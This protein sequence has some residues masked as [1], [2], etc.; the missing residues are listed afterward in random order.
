[1]NCASPRLSSSMAAFVSFLTQLDATAAGVSATTNTP[2]PSSPRP[3]AST[4]F[5]PG[6]MLSG[7]DPG[8]P[9]GAVQVGCQPVGELSVLVRVADEHLPR[10]AAGGRYLCRNGRRHGGRCGGS[11]LFHVLVGP[12]RP[13]RRLEVGERLTPD[14]ALDQELDHLLFGHAGREVVVHIAEVIE[15]EGFEVFVAEGV[16]QE[17]ADV[18]GGGCHASL[19]WMR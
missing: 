2:L 1:M 11:E 13:Q 14:A 4:H 3:I 17:T 5:S 12:L 8:A 18:G 9:A 6:W 10:I 7:S 16:D 19:V 15:A